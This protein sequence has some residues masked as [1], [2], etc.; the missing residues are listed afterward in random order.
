VDGTGR[1]AAWLFGRPSGGG[2]GGLWA[3]W[4]VLRGLGAI[5]FSVF[6][7]LAFQIHGLI[8]ETGILPAT[9]YLGRVAHTFPGAARFWYAPTLL[10]MGAGRGALTTLVAVGIVAATLLFLNVSPRISLLVAFVAFLSFIGAAQ[11]FS[12]YQSDGMLLEAAFIA[13]FYAPGGLRPGLGAGEPPSRAA[14]FLLLWECFRIYFESGVVKLASGDRTWRDLSAMDHYYE[15]GPLP[16]WLGWYVQ[17]L[18]PGFHA[19]TA[20][21]TLVVELGLV[22]MFFFGRRARLACFALVTSLQI[23]IIATANYAFLNYL[24]LLLGFLLLDDEHYE[25]AKGRL[26]GTWMGRYLPV[27]KAPKAE[28]V[29]AGASWKMAATAIPLAW[30]FYAT[31]ADFLLSGAPPELLWLRWP[32]GVI[33]PF[34]I[35]NRY[36]LFAVMTSA[37]YEIEFQGSRDGVSWTPYP[38]RYKPQALEAAPGIYAPYQPRF[39]WNLWFASLGLC[40]DNRWVLQAEARLAS[41]DPDVLALF[42]SNP[43]EGAPPTYV[44]T[45]A[46]Q[47]WFTDLAT[48]RATGRWWRRDEIGPYC[49][50]WDAKAQRVLARPPGR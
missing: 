19:F 21:L 11:D 24:V 9:D 30:V 13:L 46:F 2:R 28:T 50:T 20:A 8:G 26:Q 35:A 3:R 38:F 16:T 27:A 49:P 41:G 17:H 23:G 37:R 22:W 31:C 39:E 47:Y 45:V 32:V 40:R 10:W 33:A 15:N 29:S 6:Y 25:W 48:R 34:R 36:G 7:S 1:H 14:G 42:A 5:F 12:S 18:P 43:F 44:R 4:I